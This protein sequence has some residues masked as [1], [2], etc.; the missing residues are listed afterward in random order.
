MKWGPILLIDDDADDID[1]MEQAIVEIGFENKLIWLK[2]TQQAWDYLQTTQEQPFI[3]FCDINLPKQNGI[4]FKK[5]ID[6]DPHLRRKSIPFVFYSTSISRDLINRAYLELTVQGFFQKPDNYT[7]VKQALKTIL[8][9]WML[10][11]HPNTF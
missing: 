3:I 11:K 10:S 6:S 4:E 2:N 5:D 8:D 1:I 9:Y 7:R